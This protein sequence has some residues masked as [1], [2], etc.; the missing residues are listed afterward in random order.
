[1]LSGACLFDEDQSG[2]S[3]RA[4]FSSIGNLKRDH[5][6]LPVNSHPLTAKAPRGNFWLRIIDLCAFYSNPY[7]RPI[8]F[9]QNHLDPAISHRK[10]R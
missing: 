10:S 8:V 7:R 4:F 5:Q 2:S 3:I 6:T 9:A 1:M